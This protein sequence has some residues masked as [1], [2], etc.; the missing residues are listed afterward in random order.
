MFPGVEYKPMKAPD[1][2]AFVLDI[3]RFGFTDYRKE[4]LLQ[5]V[6]RFCAAL[7]THYLRYGA[8]IPE[9]TGAAWMAI[10]DAIGHYDPNEKGGFCTLLAFWLR[11]HYDNVVYKYFIQNK[12]YPQDKLNIKLES[13]NRRIFYDDESTELI[14]KIEDP[15]SGAE[16]EQIQNVSLINSIVKKSYLS[17]NEK[18]FLRLSL[19]PESPTLE[20]IGIIKGC[21]R[22]YARQVIF[23]IVKK[24][25]ETA[26]NEKRNTV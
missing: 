22:E 15:K 3:Q 19:M 26:K 7:A 12:R 10:N 16:I 20:E 17:K 11:H 2:K 18:E 25:R 23:K 4:R 1:L 13:L 21:S 5:A 24:L 14:D 8:D 6:G 9:F